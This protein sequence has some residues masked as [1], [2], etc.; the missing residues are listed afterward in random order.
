M[1]TFVSVVICIQIV[2]VIVSVYIWL[3]WKFG[4]VNLEIKREKKG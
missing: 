3:A 1:A 4:R 2:L